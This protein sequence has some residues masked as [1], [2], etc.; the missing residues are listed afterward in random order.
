M[1]RILGIIFLCV[2]LI[3][4]IL[5]MDYFVGNGFLASFFGGHSITLM[6]TLLGLN[7]VIVVFLMQS[8]TAIEVKIDKTIFIGTRKEVKQNT[9]F[10]LVIFVLHFFVLVVMPKT[11]HGT[12]QIWQCRIA[13]LCKATNLILFCLSLYCIHEVVRAAFTIS[14]MAITDKSSD[15]DKKKKI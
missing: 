14:K 12:S 4:P 10:M 5:V 11:S 1:I 2:L 13:F 7:F 3:V 8:M 9:F 15:P 6:G